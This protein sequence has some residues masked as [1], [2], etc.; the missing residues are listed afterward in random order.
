[1]KYGVESSQDPLCISDMPYQPQ[2]TI[3]EL[4]DPA[5]DFVLYCHGDRTVTMELLRADEG[6]VR[7]VR[8]STVMKR[9]GGGGEMGDPRE[10]SQTSGIIRRDSHFRIFGVNR[11]GIEP[12]SHRWEASGLTARPPWPPLY[13]GY[14]GKEVRLLIS[15]Q[16]ELVSIPSWIA[17]YYRKWESCQDDATGRRIFSGISHFPLPFHSGTAPYS[18]RFT[19]IGSQDLDVMNRLNVFTHSLTPRCFQSS[20]RS[21][22]LSAHKHDE[23]QP[24]VKRSLTT[25]QKCMRTFSTPA[26]CESRNGSPSTILRFRCRSIDGLSCDDLAVSAFASRQG[27]PGS[28]IG[29]VAPGFSQLVIVTGDA[30]GRKI[31][32]GI[33]R[34]P[35]PLHSCA[36]APYLPRFALI[37]S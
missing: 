9:V 26:E 7:K 5:H 34:F 2:L 35:P 16:G 23:V 21:E 24:F 28:I 20:R 29:G 19:L 10:N 25:R 4:G 1:M 12:G 37:D 27:E 8:N 15:H 11:L 18:P 36:A 3:D 33:S 13:W 14:G 17:Q 6:E 22:F 31:F 30:A 32:L